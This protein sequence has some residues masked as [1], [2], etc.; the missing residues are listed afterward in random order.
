MKR[1]LQAGMI[2]LV[3]LGAVASGA[4]VQKPGPTAKPAKTAKA[5]ASSP[6]LRLLAAGKL[7]K[8]LALLEAEFA[9]APENARVGL[10]R[11]RCLMDLGRWKGSLAAS[12]ALLEKFPE[13]ADIR[14]ET[15][16]LLLLSF[17]PAAA[18][19]TWRPLMDNPAQ[20]GKV[21]P[22][23]LAA[24]L[25]QHQ[26][27]EAEALALRARAAGVPFSDSA[28]WL[29]ARA[30][31]CPGRVDFLETLARRHPDNRENRQA[32]QAELIL[33]AKGG[34]AT[35]VVE[36]LP[37]SLEASHFSSD[38][39]A[40]LNGRKK[41]AFIIDSGSQAVFLWGRKLV[42]R[43]H[44]PLLGKAVATSLGSEP[45]EAQRVLLGRL[46]VGPVAISRV[47]AIYLGNKYRSRI[48][49][50]G[51]APFLDYIVDWDRRKG[52]YTFWPAGTPAETI[53]GKKPDAILPVR[54][55]R[56]IPLVPV[57]ING[58]GPYPFVFDTGGAS[59]LLS[60]GF[61]SRL[62]LEKPAHAG[63][64]SKTGKSVSGE[65]Y[66]NYLADADLGVGGESF[67]PPW[68]RVMQ[69]AQRFSGPVYGILGRDFTRQYRIVFDGP[70]CRIL[71]QRYEGGF[72]RDP[73]DYK[74]HSVITN[75]QRP[76]VSEPPRQ[77]RTYQQ[78]IRPKKKKN[79]G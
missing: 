2:G 57:S 39:K 79:G 64:V 21:L 24:L 9:A 53:L 37:G 71:L 15:G 17:Q 62:G 31:G 76:K 18:V 75:I 25:E 58:K 3:M 65:F 56:G 35:R 1:F 33:C 41:A 48:V 61:C 27:K 8:A 67:N 4:E 7:A 22:K 73:H 10:G 12:R 47:P 14:I 19:R 36:P 46:K 20:A 50:T 16:K 74:P 13:N 32:L 6:G 78:I 49:W 28:L 30:C 5:P 70:G 63:L 43:L 26:G 69:I 29:A 40:V 42:K 77:R 44:M 11:V 23:M 38:Y 72:Y 52:R 45:A 66:V 68:I 54:W 34:S 51:L 60:M 59:S 55:D